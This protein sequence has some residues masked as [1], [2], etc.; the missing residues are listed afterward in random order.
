MSAQP[1]KR[2]GQ[3]FLHERNTIERILDAI[4]PTPGEPMVE[5]G[6][7][8]GALTCPLLAR[9]GALDAIEIDRD[10]VPPLMERCGRAGGLRIHLQDALQ[11]DFRAL[12]D[13]RGPL[14]VV[15]NLPYNISTPLLFHLLEQ[16]DA[17]RDMHFMLQK[18]VVD[19]M[20]ARPGTRAYGRLTVMLAYRCRL[21]RLFLAGPGAFT[22]APSVWSAFVRLTPHFDHTPVAVADEQALKRVVARAFSAR[23]KTLRNALRGLLEDAQIRELGIPPDARPDTLSLEQYAHLSNA[24]GALQANSPP[25]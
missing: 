3:H 23:R 19:R 14:R 1:R 4:H 9:A 7:G 6:P 15:G 18:E 2:F 13:A 10:L 22:P 12:A 17:V 16:G 25:S 8:R 11:F 21:E 24:L 20:T 5:I